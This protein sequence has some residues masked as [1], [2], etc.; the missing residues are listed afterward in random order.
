M[1][2]QPPQTRL[3]LVGRLGNARDHE[4][5]TEFVSIYEPLILR[6]LRQNGLQDCDS[7][8]VCQQVL[9]AVAKDIDTW[10]PDGKHG[11][12]RRWL[13]RVARNRVIKFLMSQRKQPRAAGGTSAHV[14]MRQ[15]P[16]ARASISEVFD[17]EYRERVLVWAAEQIREEFRESTWNAFWRT[18]IDGRPVAEV[19]EELGTTAGNIYVARSRIM[20][21]LKTQ[22]KHI[23]EGEEE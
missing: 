12:F 15:Q 4:A 16:D 13:F 21:R 17:R 23:L 7:S 14:L 5:W 3:T 1:K 11:S 22:V 8:D 9:Q 6:L 2:H 19:A 18:C 10:K 20:S